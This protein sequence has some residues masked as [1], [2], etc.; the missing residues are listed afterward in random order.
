MDVTDQ[1]TK[2]KENKNEGAVIECPSKS[3]IPAKNPLVPWQRMPKQSQKRNR[4]PD[5]AE[6]K[7]TTP[8]SKLMKRKQHKDQTRIA[9]QQQLLNEH[10]GMNSEETNI[11]NIDTSNSF[12][13]LEVEDLETETVPPEDDPLITKPDGN[14]PPKKNEKNKNNEKNRTSKPPPIIL[15]GIE[16]LQKLSELIEEVVNKENYTYRV[17]SKNQLITAG[18]VENYKRMIEI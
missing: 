11:V 7:W 8:K 10:R 4:S 13:D 9:A 16:D 2:N 17:V 18:D 3:T 14:K 15:Y 6:E 1:K 12:S 5:Q